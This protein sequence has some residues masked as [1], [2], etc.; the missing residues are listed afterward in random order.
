MSSDLISLRKNV[1]DFKGRRAQI[2]EDLKKA[3]AEIEASQKEIKISEEAQMIIQLV[4]KQTQDQLKF[5]IENPITAALGGV[6]DDPYEFELRFEQRRG[7]T[8]ADLIFKSEK[9]EF[10]DLMFS[11]GGGEVDV[12]ALGLQAAA[13]SIA[14]NV[15]RFLLL[16][17]PL[18][19]LKSEDKSLEKRG[20]LMIGELARQ[21]DIQILMVSHI[22]EQQEGADSIFRFELA[23]GGVTKV[24]F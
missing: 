19:H 8:E 20:A 2:S 9:G 12:A 3:L 24:N 21:L 5:Y 7:Q 4:A 13:L 23:E 10:K 15:R 11:G 17:E 14:E 18:K 16:D 22:P 1:D 6:F